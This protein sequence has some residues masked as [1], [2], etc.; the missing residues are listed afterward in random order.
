MQTVVRTNKK[1]C[2]TLLFLRTHPG[3]GQC[4]TPSRYFD[5]PSISILE[6]KFCHHEF[7]RLMMFWMNLNLVYAECF[8]YPS[9]NRCRPCS[10]ITNATPP[11]ESVISST[12][13]WAKSSSMSLSS[14][15]R[16]RKAKRAKVGRT[17]GAIPGFGIAF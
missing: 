5:I 1:I 17:G 12:S 3:L 10:L 4:A 8:S 11:W 6:I 13:P 15:V 2:H 14:A 7:G 9:A 16:L